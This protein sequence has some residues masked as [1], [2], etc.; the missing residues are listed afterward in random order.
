M[1]SVVI[2]NPESRNGKTRNLEEVIKSALSEVH[3][4]IHQTSFP[5][6]ATKIARLAV[7]QKADLIIAAG[8][9]GTI[10]EVINVIAKK[11]IALGIIP[12]GTANDLASL[13][14]L[15]SD[16]NEACKIIQNQN[17]KEIDLISVNG[18]YYAT[19]GGLGFACDVVNFANII[20]RLGSVGRA[21]SKTLGSKLYIFAVIAVLITRVRYNKSLIINYGDNRV[22][23][24]ALSLMF[25]NQ[26]FLGKN[27]KMS[28]GAVNDDGLFDICLINSYISRLKIIHLLAKILKGT[29]V[30]LPSVKIMKADSIAIKSEM[31]IPFFGDGEVF[32]QDTE[33]NIRLIPKALK[34]IV[35][36]RKRELE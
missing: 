20:K 11:D 30:F 18:K 26:A 1:K 15:P 16:V 5:G 31:P 17:I 25:N 33:F 32:R 4:K 10:N 12:L 8:G 35:P 9:D 36:Q 27:I 23:I 13:Y 7:E 28:P 24:N 22:A 14:N 21:L 3:P 6:H 34:L 19:A 2:I 29:H